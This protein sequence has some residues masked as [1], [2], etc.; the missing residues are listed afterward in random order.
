MSY[1]DFVG[2]VN[3]WNVLPGAYVT[4]S[5]WATFSK[6]NKDSRLLELACTSGFTSREL[7]ILTGCSGVGIDIS[8][9]SIEMARYNKNQY[10]PNI[11]INYIHADGN[12]FETD[13]KFSHV[14]VGAALKFFP[15][16]QET[17]KRIISEHLT[18]GGFLLASP[19]YVIK[20]IPEELVERARKTF[21][22]TITT[23]GYKEIM[24]TYAG[25]EIL[26]EDR[27][28]IIKESVQELQSYCGNTI[29]RGCKIRNITNPLVKKAMFDRLVD[30]KSISNDLR[31]YQMYAVLVL[32][33]RASIYP[34]R[35]IELF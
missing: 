1:T 29:E 23:E 26:F 33:Y 12:T 24:R 16:P 31:P 8:E 7:A 27:C 35:F 9:P 6:L 15:D 14:V 20:D 19:F 11:D 28:E 4:L 2:F 17:V 5:K 13:K 22:I 25:F 32:R 3:Q 18:D 30:I 10:A 34:N 21:G